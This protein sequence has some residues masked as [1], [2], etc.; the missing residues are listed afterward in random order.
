MNVS[1]SYRLLVYAH[2]GF[3]FH[4][5][6]NIQT[7][8]H[9]KYFL[10]SKFLVWNVKKKNYI[11]SKKYVERMRSKMLKQQN[12]FYKFV[13]GTGSED[14]F[15]YPLPATW[16]DR[17]KFLLSIHFYQLRVTLFILI[18]FTSSDVPSELFVWTV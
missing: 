6:P 14:L 17:I 11:K 3:I 16:H 4:E 18:T 1:Q 8:G 13:R 9:A 7:H 2:L 15:M 5:L 12:G 10:R